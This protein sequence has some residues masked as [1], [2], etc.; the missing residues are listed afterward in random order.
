MPSLEK[1]ATKFLHASDLHLGSH[2]YRNPAR[3]YDYINTLK[4]ILAVGIGHSV[5]FYIFGGDFFTSLDILPGYFQEI[6]SI[7][8]EFKEKHDVPLIGIEGNHDIRRYSHGKKF[9]RGQSWIK[10]LADLG[11]IIL[12]D[13]ES[14]VP[15]PDLFKSFDFKSRKGGKIEIK[16]AVI[17]GTRFLRE[18]QELFLPAIKDSI[19]F[20]DNKYHILLQHFG[21]AGQMNNVPGINYAKIKILKQKVNYLALGHYHLQ[22]QIDGWIFNPGS[23]EAVSTIEHSFQRGIFLVNIYRD[24]EFKKYLTKVRALR[25]KNRSFMWRTVCIPNDYRVRNSTQINDFIVRELYNSL[26]PEHLKKYH[27]Y[28]GNPILYLKLTGRDR[29]KSRKIPLKILSKKIKD[30]LKFIHVKIFEKFTKSTITL[31]NYL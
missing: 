11:L 13:T 8:R 19:P 15:N 22:Y 2:Q 6:I 29:F 28:G 23:P 7:L 27:E 25:L 9:I 17:Y 21:I 31:M 10:I 14:D 24:E 20:D 1:S 18:K 12:L 3:S 5:D 16:D 26:P 30:E 4:E